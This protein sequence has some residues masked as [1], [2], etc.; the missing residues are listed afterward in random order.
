MHDGV[1]NGG[2]LSSDSESGER[3]VDGTEEDELNVL[4]T[5]MCCY[6]VYT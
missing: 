2:T 3:D 1:D 5:S 4:V 6:S